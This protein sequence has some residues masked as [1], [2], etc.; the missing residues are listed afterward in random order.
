[1]NISDECYIFVLRVLFQYFCVVV[2]D[3]RLY[4]SVFKKIL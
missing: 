4:F 3:F 2:G 1:M